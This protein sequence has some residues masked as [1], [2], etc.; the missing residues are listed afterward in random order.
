METHKEKRQSRMTAIHINSWV[1]MGIMLFLA[2]G[3]I[4]LIIQENGSMTDTR[5]LY[6]M[7]LIGGIIWGVRAV[8]LSFARVPTECNKC[9]NKLNTE[10]EN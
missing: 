8:A 2:V 9:G 7:G 4:Y 10:G 6:C 3:I 5:F 1:A